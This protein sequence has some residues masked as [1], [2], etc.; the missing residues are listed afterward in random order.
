[1]VASVYGLGPFREATI[2]QLLFSVALRTSVP[3]SE[4]D[5][6]QP[7]SDPFSPTQ[8]YLGRVTR[9]TSFSHGAG[10]ACKLGL[11]DLSEVLRSLPGIADPAVLVDA[12]TRDDAAVYRL[13]DDRA[14]VATVDFFTPIV[15]D[16]ATWGAIAAANALS[17]VYAMGGTPLF[18]LNIT[19]WPRETLPLSL[20]G[21][22][23]AGGAQVCAEARCAVVGG[24]T[25]DDREPKFGMAVVGEVHP[26]RVWSNAGAR[27]GD[28]LVL[29][30]P[31]GTGVLTTALKR[32]LV[33]EAGISE[34]VA[35]MRTLNAGAARAGRTVP[36]HAA[37][38]VTGFGLLGHLRNILNA[39]DVGAEVRGGAVPVLAGV[40]ELVTAGAVA[41][42]SKR[43]LEAMDTVTWDRAVADVDRVVLTDAQTSGGLLFAVPP[44]AVEALTAALLAERTLAAAVIGTITSG[45]RG[46]IRV[47]P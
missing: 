26:A 25:V 47:T 27:T 36:V 40:R 21:E 16:A 19:G 23:L 29:T 10:C 11:A 24:H 20:L 4:N 9:L 39:S 8:R 7:R 2:S 3:P 14:L 35:S 32:G 41:G 6:S 43:N 33:D 1:M 38:D 34:A 44:E 15:D 18:A 13:S 37:T 17:D 28:V 42:G 31:L 5:R 30:K 46:T 22:V 12:S 45:A